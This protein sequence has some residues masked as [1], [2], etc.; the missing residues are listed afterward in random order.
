MA[1]P[2]LPVGAADDVVAVAQGRDAAAADLVA[3]GGADQAVA[4]GDSHS[5]ALPS[6]LTQVTAPTTAP[7]FCQ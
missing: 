7:P 1:A 2:F 5:A 4:G 6:P 3:V